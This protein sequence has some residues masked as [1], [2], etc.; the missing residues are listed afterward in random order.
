MDAAQR[1]GEEGGALIFFCDNAQ[2][3]A[4][5]RGEAKTGR[6]STWIYWYFP[7]G[8]QEHEK[9]RGLIPRTRFVRASL[10]R[11]C[12]D[13]RTPP[14][15]PPPQQPRTSF[16]SP[17][18]SSRTPPVS[19]PL[20]IPAK[21][22]TP[23]PE[24]VLLSRDPPH[25]CPLSPVARNWGS[26]VLPTPPTPLPPPISPERDPPPPLPR[27]CKHS[28]RPLNPMRHGTHALNPPL[29]A[30][31]PGEVPPQQAPGLA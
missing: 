30:L 20:P 10:D 31:F 4:N 21:F 14:P 1:E 6:I 12:N 16:T 22:P 24:H 13:Q 9:S 5:Q 7:D 27:R 25:T 28:R 8:S 11:S 3:F 18:S 15:P 17:G 26:T 19:S 29:P 2:A 23:P